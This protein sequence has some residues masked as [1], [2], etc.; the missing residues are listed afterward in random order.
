LSRKASRCA[1]PKRYC[2]SMIAR[3]S[4]ANTTSC[5][6][7]ACVPTTRPAAPEATASSI[8]VRPFPRRLPVS[9]ATPTPRGSSQCTSLRKCCSARISVGA[10]SAHHLVI[11]RGS[12]C[13]DDRLARDAA[14]QQAVKARA[15]GRRDLGDHA[16][17]VSKISAAST[18]RN[19]SWSWGT[20]AR[21]R[22]DARTPSAWASCWASSSPAAAATGCVGLSAPGTGVGGAGNAS[23]RP[24]GR[25][26][27]VRQQLGQGGARPGDALRR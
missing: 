26:A 16:G 7:T 19:L 24:A 21:A 6:I 14:L 3:P 11:A 13:S 9:Q 27:L 18:P 5:W 10:I 2:S 25:G 20:P 23:A 8:C 1:T 17:C 22:S 12:E 15:R 4:L